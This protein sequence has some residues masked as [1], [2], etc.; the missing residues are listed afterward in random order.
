MKM[1][2][3]AIGVTAQ[4]LL[5]ASLV[6]ATILDGVAMLVALDP[7]SLHLQVLTLYHKDYYIPF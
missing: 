5:G 1:L 2:I 7:L 6:F 4:V 3:D